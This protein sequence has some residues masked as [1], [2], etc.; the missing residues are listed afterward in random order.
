MQ[1]IQIGNYEYNYVV[2]DSVPPGVL[3]FQ[4]PRTGREVGRIVNIKESEIAKTE[5]SNQDVSELRRLSQQGDHLSKSALFG[6]WV[7]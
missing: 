1:K 2:D 3:I 4:D 7:W 6:R 5:L